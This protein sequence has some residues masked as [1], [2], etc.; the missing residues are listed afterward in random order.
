MLT[1]I[2]ERI[3]EISI[4]NGQTEINE[5]RRTEMDD[6]Q[7]KLLQLLK[8]L[9][10][11]C[12]END[13]SYFLQGKT[14]LVALVFQGFIENFR[15]LS[16][17]MTSGNARKLVHY[18]E[19][20]CSSD[21][22]WE[23][24]LNSP[25]Y[26]RISIRYGDRDSTDIKI[27][28]FGN[29]SYH[30][31]SIAI[32]IYRYKEKNKYHEK[33]SNFYELGWEYIQNPKLYENKRILSSFGTQIMM[34]LVGKKRFARYLYN[35]LVTKNVDESEY[36][37]YS[38]YYKQRKFFKPE[39]VE[40]TIRIPFEDTELPVMKSWE[41]Y[42]RIIFGKNWINRIPVYNPLNP[43]LRIV[44]T[45]IPFEE[46]LSYLKKRNVDLSD[47]W[48]TRKKFIIKKSRVD[49]LTSQIRQYHPKL[50]LSGDRYILWKKYNKK[51]L[52]LNELRKSEE[53]DKLEEELQECID[54]MR[55]YSSQHL[56]LYF[57]K[58]IFDLVDYV[59]KEKGNPNFCANI[60]KKV[61]QGHTAPLQVV[62]NKGELLLENSTGALMEAT[63]EDVD[64]LLVYLKRHVGNC[65]YLYIDL[66]KY[67]LTNPNMKIWFSQD[68]DG[69][70]LVVMKYHDSFQVYS[71]SD[72]WDLQAVIR[73]LSEYEV[74]M[75]SGK[76][77]IIERIH[78][79]FE[80]EYNLE[81]GYV[82]QL[83]A[84]RKFDE[85]VPIERVT[86]SSEC[87]AIA[88]FI[89]S[90]DSIGGYYEVDNL[91]M[92]LKERME[93]GMGRSLVIRGQD[94]Y[95]GHIAT[96]AEFDGFAV[97]AGLLS[98]NNGTNIPYGSMLESRLVHD[99]LDEG[100]TIYTFVTEKRR[101]KFFELMG[102]KQY[103]K[104][105]K[106]TIKNR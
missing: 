2:R 71:E 68:E 72:Q 84:F 63:D 76:D 11:I 5:D 26:P 1:D 45:E 105:G 28:N 27:T 19:K 53:T 40:Q 48:R 96:Y 33:I 30:G 103:G 4:Q 49:E 3:H 89:C 29:Y 87:Q 94:G 75:I 78:P 31:I 51:W 55:S 61:P 36:Y 86:D 8:E 16:I 39:M 77:S 101:A 10:Q 70:N 17:G 41:E 24:L 92:Q 67:R 91:A 18:L 34:G 95:L 7:K 35:R 74:G 65:I 102:C 56:G 14:A 12:K 37:V 88:H 42:L 104:Y 106:M 58:R 82:F 60:M 69:I 64:A 99:L 43:A 23:C 9:D 62:N 98:V 59:M 38:P 93:N 25:D 15:N 66:A 22:Y 46:Y 47:I 79:Y 20:N 6:Y 97:T 73:L 85:I 50:F 83:T 44:E 52:Y 80:K 21:R 90:N 54:Q 100:F 32:E 57:D 81:I 13:I